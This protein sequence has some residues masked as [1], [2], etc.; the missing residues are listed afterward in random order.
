MGDA[1]AGKIQHDAEMERQAGAAGM[2]SSG[3]VYQQHLGALRKGY[4]RLL[5]QVPLAQSQQA[6]LIGEVD[7]AFGHRRGHETTA[8]Q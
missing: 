2:I 1:D 5:K 3:G 7:E 6:R 4:Q 8:P